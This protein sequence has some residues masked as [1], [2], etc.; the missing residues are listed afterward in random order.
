MISANVWVAA[1]EFEFRY[2]IM[3]I[4]SIIWFPHDGNLISVS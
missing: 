4:W 1:K 3:G 2:H